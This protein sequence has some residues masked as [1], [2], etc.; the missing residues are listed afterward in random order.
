MLRSIFARRYWLTALF[1]LLVVYPHSATAQSTGFTYQGRLNDNNQVANGNFDF[2]FKLFTALT[3]GTQDGTPREVLNVAVSN[4]V[5]TVLVDFGAGAFPGADRFLEIAVRPAGGGAFTTLTPRQQITLTPYAIKSASA[6]QASFALNAND[7]QNAVNAT[8]ATQLGGIAANQFV[9]TNDSRLSDARNPLPNNGNYIQNRTTPQTTSNFNVSGNGTLGGTLTSN[10]VSA[11]TTFN[12]GTSPVLRSPGTSNFFAGQGA[13]FP[14]AVIGDGNSFFGVKAG[15]LNVEGNSNAFFGF[16]AGLRNNEGSNNSYFGT[17]AG[18]LNS[19][20]SGNSFFGTEA[21]DA[22]T[23]GNNNTMIGSRAD[24]GTNN[25]T[26]STAIGHRAIVESSNALVLGGVNGKNGATEDTNVGIGTSTPSVPLEIE[27]DVGFFQEPTLR[28]THY[29]RT[30]DGPIVGARSSRG[31]RSAPTASSLND[32]LLIIQADGYTGSGF[33]TDGRVGIEFIAA[34]NWGPAPEGIGT[35]TAIHFRTTQS[36]GS[37]SPAT[38]MTINHDGN[39]AIGTNFTTPAQKL[40][41]LGNVRVGFSGTVGCVEDRD[42]TVIAGSC[43]SDVRLKRNIT[44]FGNVLNNFSKLRPVNFFWRANEFADRHF[45][46][47]QSFGL[48]AQEVEQTFPE[49]VSTDERGYKVVNYSKLPLL[50]I[51]AV[52]ELKV[53]NDALKALL[54]SQQRRFVKQLAAQQTQLSTQRREMEALK[55]LVCLSHAGAEVCK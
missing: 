13:G 53:E 43:S 4:G 34:E 49:L 36:G 7:A 8:N 50:T 24:V 47:R 11:A 51:Q 32:E 41:V 38:K 20:G 9:Q 21:G 5:F 19:T 39:V 35:G 55:R 23:T 54:Q 10:V 29:S 25:L 44:P 17:D 14:L 18:R 6:D 12:I 52:T 16:E 42:G 30:G 31:T 26:N 40:D 2:E 3:G 45:G 37:A 1:I 28:I 15:N 22:N 48:I 27:Q 46:T 33:T